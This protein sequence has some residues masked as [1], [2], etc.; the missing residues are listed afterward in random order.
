MSMVLWGLQGT[1]IVHLSMCVGSL[2]W[3]P[4]VA[5]R[6]QGVAQNLLSV[7]VTASVSPAAHVH[8]FF[9]T[10]LLAWCCLSAEREGDYGCW[11][12]PT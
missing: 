6:K 2:P 11:C 10:F 4:P 8:L 5:W 3:A 7:L 12:T 9:H 1:A